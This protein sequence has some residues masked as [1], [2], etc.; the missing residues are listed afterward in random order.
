ME[1]LYRGMIVAEGPSP[2]QQKPWAE[3]ADVGSHGMLQPVM[4]FP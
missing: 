1:P 4:G 2:A 3:E